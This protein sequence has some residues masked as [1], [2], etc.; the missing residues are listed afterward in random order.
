[1]PNFK[2]FLLYKV[3]PLG[4]LVLCMEN[5]HAMEPFR[6]WQRPYSVSSLLNSL[7]GRDENGTVAFR[8][9]QHSRF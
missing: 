8:N 5:L 6:Y 3:I 9:W 7:R 2:I 1:M 4:D